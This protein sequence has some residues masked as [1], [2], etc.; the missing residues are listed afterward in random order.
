MK[1]IYFQ[2]ELKLEFLPDSDLLTISVT[3]GGS[4]LEFDLGGQEFT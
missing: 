2:P 4:G 3:K 1:N